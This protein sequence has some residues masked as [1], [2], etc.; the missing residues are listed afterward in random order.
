MRQRTRARV[1]ALQILYQID[2][3][4]DPVDDVLEQFWRDAEQSPEVRGF[5]TQLVK[6]A[7]KNLEEID[8]LIVQR[9]EH[10]KLSRMPAIDRSILRLGTYELLYRDDIP[11]KVAINEAVELAKNY[12][13]PDSGQFINGILDKLM[14]RE[15]TSST[16]L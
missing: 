6:G 13:T 11:P 16:D 14:I 4:G 15:R 2:I 1:Y 12:S 10:W 9:S 5:A 3:T 7:S 8:A